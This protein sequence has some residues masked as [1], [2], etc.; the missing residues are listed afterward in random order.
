MPAVGTAR[1]GVPRESYDVS[2]DA[3]NIF[4]VAMLPDV[5]VTIAGK[6][7]GVSVNVS[8]AVQHVAA[9]VA[10]ENDIFNLELFAHGGGSGGNTYLRAVATHK[11]SHTEALDAD[12]HTLTLGE[13]LFDLR[14]EDVVADDFHRRCG[15]FDAKY[16]VV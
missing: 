15:L 12:D 9:A 2:D 13:Q 14:E 10:E 11:R 1:D 16:G 3:D 5:V 7:Q 8:Y 4:T 6:G